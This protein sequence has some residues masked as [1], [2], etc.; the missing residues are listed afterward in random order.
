MYKYTYNNYRIEQTT[1]VI[2]DSHTRLFKF[3]TQLRK[4]KLLTKVNYN[5]NLF[6]YEYQDCT[7]MLKI[8]APHNMHVTL[9]RHKCVHEL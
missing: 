6:L 1:A 2:G 9:N 4:T 8:F 7:Q 3:M 5:V